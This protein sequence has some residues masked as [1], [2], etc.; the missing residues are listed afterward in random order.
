MGHRLSRMDQHKWEVDN[1]RLQIR[2]LTE[3]RD[4]S[5]HLFTDEEHKFV[6]LCLLQMELSLFTISIYNKYLNRLTNFLEDKLTK[7]RKLL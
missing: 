7:Q 5:L 2:E 4:N 1:R 6:S 3:M